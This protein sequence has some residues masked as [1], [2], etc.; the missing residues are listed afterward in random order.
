MTVICSYCHRPW[1]ENSPFSLQAASSCTVAAGL[2]V[3]GIQTPKDA[4]VQVPRLQHEDDILQ[5]SQMAGQPGQASNMK[6]APDYRI[7]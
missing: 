6:P 5:V 7:Y 3:E 1:Q 4:K 2:H